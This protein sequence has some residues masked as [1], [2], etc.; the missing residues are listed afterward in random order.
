MRLRSQRTPLG[1]TRL[2]EL[3]EHSISAIESLTAVSPAEVTLDPDGEFTLGLFLTDV[4]SSVAHDD[5]QPGTYELLLYDVST[6]SAATVQVTPDHTD[7]GGF[8]VRQHGPRRLWDEA[9]TAYTW[10]T[11]HGRPT[12]TRYGLTLTPDTQTVWLDDPDNT[13]AVSR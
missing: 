4:Q 5:D 13:I 2:A 12:R 3:V 1:A 7:D 9:E 8:P 10:W 6:D 11:E